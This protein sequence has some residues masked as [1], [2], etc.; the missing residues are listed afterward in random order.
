M[1]QCP[2]K[3]PSD[4]FINIKSLAL[5]KLR[6]VSG[7]SGFVAENFAGHD[8]AIGQLNSLFDFVSYI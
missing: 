6:F 4:F 8:D 2:F 7:V 5:K 1:K 3:L